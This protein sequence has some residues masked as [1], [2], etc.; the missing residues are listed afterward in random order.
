[1]AVAGGSVSACEI[2]VCYLD[3]FGRQRERPATEVGEVPFEEL[4]PLECPV[5]YPGR[6]SFVTN[7]WASATGQ[8]LACGSLR[9]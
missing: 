1:M 3:R 8:L 7:A 2:A 9:Q 4:A 6:Q 5:P